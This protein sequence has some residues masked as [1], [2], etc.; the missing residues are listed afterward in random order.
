MLR[1]LSRRKRRLFYE[2]LVGTRQAVL[3]EQRRG[4]CW[5]GLTDNYVRVEVQRAG[6]LQNG[7]HAVTLVERRDDSMLGTMA[8]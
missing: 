7:F 3:F 4:P 8:T 6:N 2:T 1:E 5:A